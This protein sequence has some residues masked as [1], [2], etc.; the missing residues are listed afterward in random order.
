MIFGP[1]LQVHMI[2]LQVKIFKNGYEQ[3]SLVTEVEINWD[4]ISYG[5]EIWKEFLLT[6]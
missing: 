5:Y 4:F 1:I 2:Q 3:A 6:L